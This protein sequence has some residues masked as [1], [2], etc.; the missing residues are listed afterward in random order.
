VFG[1]LGRLPVAGDRVT[2]HGATFTVKELEGRRIETLAV[3]VVGAGERQR[4]DE[5]QERRI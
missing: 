4:A 1:A 3:K 2:A 5:H